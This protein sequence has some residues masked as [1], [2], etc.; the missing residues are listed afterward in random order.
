MTVSD[1]SGMETPEIGLLTKFQYCTLLGNGQIRPK[2]RVLN[3]EKVTYSGLNPL[4]GD[5]WQF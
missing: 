2:M 1:F 5:K 3:S 4:N